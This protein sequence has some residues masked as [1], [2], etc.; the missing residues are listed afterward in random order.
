MSTAG[1][2]ASSTSPLSRIPISESMRSTDRG[3][4]GAATPIEASR[5]QPTGTERMTRSEAY[6]YIA[7][8]LTNIDFKGPEEWEPY[9]M[10]PDILDT[11][12]NPD[13]AEQKLHVA[14][15]RVKDPALIP[16]DKPWTIEVYR[17]LG[18]EFR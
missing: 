10:R 13:K 2:S 18:Y 7:G 5:P 12:P 6:T 4:M 1:R 3:R 9:I 8:S 15:D 14:I 11:E 16:Q 17:A